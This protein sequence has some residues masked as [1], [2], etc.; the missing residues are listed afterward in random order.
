M[1]HPPSITSDITLQS[2]LTQ[3]LE[4]NRP[5]EEQNRK[6]V[7]LD[8]KSIEVF[9]GSLN[10]LKSLWESVSNF[11]ILKYIILSILSN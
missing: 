6:G 4:F 5:K 3:I 10:M 11:I 9:E 2:F 7:K 8:F 1:G